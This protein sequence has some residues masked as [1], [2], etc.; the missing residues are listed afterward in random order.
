MRDLRFEVRWQVDNGD[1]PERTLLRTNTTSNTEIFGYECDFRL[2]GYFDTK[3]PTAYDR[4]GFLA[5]LSAFL[6]RLC[7][8]K[9]LRI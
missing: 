3:A 4:A 6:E 9:T 2:G 7:Q 8:Q 5:F 1:S